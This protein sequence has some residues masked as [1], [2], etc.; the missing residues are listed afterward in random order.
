MVERGRAV[1]GDDD[2]LARG[3]SIVLDDVRCSEIVESCLHLSKRATDGRA[4]GRHTGCCHDLLGEGLA[5]LEPCGPGARPEAGD[6]ACAHGIGHSRDQG[7]L[8]ADDDEI[9]ANRLGE[10]R[11]RATI[12]R[13]H[14]MSL[15]LL[16]DTRIAGRDVHLV[17][18]GV[19]S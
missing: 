16:R 14:R 2:T 17:H 8:G 4:R 13:I 12:K 15:R 11:D 6:P 9:G 7:G 10:I 5:A 1:I 3:E 18:L 19:T